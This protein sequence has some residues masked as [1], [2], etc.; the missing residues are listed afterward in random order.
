MQINGFKKINL[1][2]Q[3][4]FKK[5]NLEDKIIYKNKNSQIRALVVEKRD[6]SFSAA[7]RMKNQQG[8]EIINI[9]VCCIDMDKKKI[10]SFL[11]Q[12]LYKDFQETTGHYRYLD[13]KLKENKM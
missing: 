1:N 7:Y 11:Y 2:N 9:D 4:N 12:E 3:K 6:I 5:I 13:K 8:Q 10:K